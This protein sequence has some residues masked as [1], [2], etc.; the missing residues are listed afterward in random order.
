MQGIHLFTIKGIPV[1][2]H[3]MF[4]LLVLVLCIGMG[5]VLQSVLLGICIVLGVLGHEFG[6]ALVAAR[7]RL[8][9]EILLHGWG[10]ITKHRPSSSAKQDF[11]ITLAGPLVNLVVGGLIYGILTLCELTGAIGV[12]VEVPALYV[13]LYLLMQVNL[14]WGIFNLLP[15][16]PMDG[17]KVFLHI[18]NRFMRADRALRVSVVVSLLFAVGILVWAL[19]GKNW[20]MVIIAGYFILMNAAEARNAFASEGGENRKALRDAS[21]RAEQ[22]YE[23]GLVAAREH[24]WKTLEMLGYQ[25]KKDAV[26]KDQVARAYEFLTIACTN[27]GKYGEALQFSGYARQSPAVKQAV[28]RCRS[29]AG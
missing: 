5:G 28:E 16:R 1:A 25:M 13:F 17:G 3:P 6:H 24:D 9:P 8:A 22:I 15:V 10:G 7:Y 20:F 4:F 27:Q 11:R 23:R 2:V 18:L 26:D 19:L 21:L 12:F 29:L 14:V